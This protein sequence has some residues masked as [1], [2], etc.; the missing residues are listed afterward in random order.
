MASQAGNS[1]VGEVPAEICS[2]NLDN[3][4][5]DCAQVTCNCCTRC[6]A[7]PTPPLFKDHP[8]YPL[9]V[10]AYPDSEDSFLDSSSPQYAAFEWLISPVN[11][12]VLSNRR[13]LQRYALAT[14]YYSTRGDDWTSSSQWLSDVHECSWY[15]S[16]A[17]FDLC[18]TLGNYVVLGLYNNNLRGTVPMEISTLA[19]T[20]GESRF[21]A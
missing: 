11:N 13:L 14:L 5:I 8:L 2:L 9:V 21:C 3:L 20:L 17:E 12:E 16:A 1:F 6:Q 15:T 19:N 4:V 7:G 18:D 10:A